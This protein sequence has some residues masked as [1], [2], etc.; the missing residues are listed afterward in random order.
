V[1]VHALEE[2]QM[3]S[4]RLRRRRPQGFTLI[5]LLVVIAIIAILI[6]LLLPAVQQ[7]REAARRTQCRNNLKQ[8]GLAVHNYLDA[9]NAFPPG[10]I[11]AVPDHN[12]KGAFVF[13]LPYIDQ[14]PLF[15]TIDQS[16][17]LM[18]GRPY[19]A[20]P[21]AANVNAARQVISGFMCPSCPVTQL[22]DY[23]YPAG[24]FGGGFPAATMTWTGARTDYCGTTGVLGVYAGIAYA[25]N[26]GGDREGAFRAAGVNGEC[27]R[28]RDVT[29]GTSNTFMIGERTGGSTIFFKTTPQPALTPTLG[30]TNG[31][32]WP[33]ALVFEHWLAG[34]LFDGTGSGGPCA[35]NCNNLRGRNF[36]CFHTGGAHFLMCDGS[37]KFVNEN[38]SAQVFA[39]SITRK[40]GEVVSLD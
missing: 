16:I 22:N 5:E 25:G 19:P 10:Y 3:P 39:G 14:A 30:V 26:A 37:V 9:F 1:F 11:A 34:S 8:I 4:S 12:V 23:A 40:K 2:L 27:A 17:P 33:D 20:A 6:A 13:L 28:I 38:I 29:D 35:I 15:N 36:H 21:L 24:A 32:S 18:N 7:A 31:G